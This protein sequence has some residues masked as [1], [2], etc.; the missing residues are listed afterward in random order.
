MFERFTGKAVFA[1]IL[2]AMAFFGIGLLGTALAMALVS[3]L[4]QAGAYAVAGAVLF[5]PPLIWALIAILSPPKRRPPPAAADL[6]RILVAALAKETPW[7]ALVSAG[8]AA[9]AN[10]FL[11]RNKSGK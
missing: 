9:V 3:V 11:S 2:I 7:I 8:L 6:T 5:L 10:L 4:G 1:A